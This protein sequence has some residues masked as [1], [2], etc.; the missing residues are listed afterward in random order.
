MVLYWSWAGYNKYV[1]TENPE[2][3]EEVSTVHYN[4]LLHR[5]PFVPLALFYKHPLSAYMYPY[6]ILPLPISSIIPSY[7]PSPTG[8]LSPTRPCREA[9]AQ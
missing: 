4:P 1:S 5:A 9:L 7:T 8:P 6:W 3:N 2:Y